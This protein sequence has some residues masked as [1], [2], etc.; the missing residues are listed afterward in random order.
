MKGQ[1]LFPGMIL[2]GFGIYFYLQQSNISIFREFYT[3]PTLLIIVGIAFLAQGYKGKDYEAI[4]PGTI[5]TGFGLHFHISSHIAIWPDHI[6]VFI[7]IISLGCLLRYQKTGNGL[8]QGVLFLI[9][10]IILLFY[11][12]VL[13]W[14]GIL[15]G[16]VNIIRD[17]WPLIIVIIGIY[18]LFIKKK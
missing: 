13:L 18:L 1:R 5:L 8:F 6:G 9:L 7:L 3:W 14:L 16:G 4:L 10:A 11:D 17:F 12:K 15:Q 2:I